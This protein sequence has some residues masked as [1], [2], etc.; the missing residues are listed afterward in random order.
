ML[1]VLTF[2]GFTMPITS[3]FLIL[4]SCLLALVPLNLFS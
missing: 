1:F 3:N 2:F 4:S